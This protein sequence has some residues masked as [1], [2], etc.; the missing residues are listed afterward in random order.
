M[1]TA[2]MAILALAAA[3]AVSCLG[4]TSSSTSFYTCDTF[5]YDDFI[6]ENPD[7]VAFA[8]GFVGNS[9]YF[10]YSAKMDDAG[11][12]FKG[13]FALSMKLDP[14]TDGLYADYSID[15]ES[16]KS[17]KGNIFAVFCQNSDE[18]C[19]PE[20]DIEFYRNASSKALVTVEPDI[21]YVANANVVLNAIKYGRGNTP[22]FGEGDYFNLIITGYNSSKSKT[23]EVKVEMAKYEGSLSY[24][25][26]WT[27]VNI[28][29]LGDITYIDFALETNRDDLK[30]D[31]IC[32]DQ[33]TTLVAMEED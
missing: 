11:K 2:K 27:K 21:C 23:G 17:T 3:A 32:M 1:K 15:K 4:N 6:T 8:K 18:S 12:V 30:L 33:L 7:S 25:K 9:G 19:M 20:H 22:K 14:A 26:E 24:V 16:G 5:S 29:S 10:A 28:K 13:G 31:R